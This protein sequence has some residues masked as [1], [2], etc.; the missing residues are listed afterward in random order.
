MLTHLT[1][2]S[3][4]KRLD[5]LLLERGLAPTRK[6]AEGLILAGEVLVDDCPVDKLGALISDTASIRLRQI[7]RKYVG[8]GGEKLEAALDYFSIDV[9]GV[10]ALDVGASTGGFTDCLL[11][12]GAKRVYAVDVGRNQLAYSLRMD[13]RV[14]VMEEIHARDLTPAH[15]SP[16]PN[17]AT[18]DLSFISLRTVLLPATAVLQAGFTALAL[19][20]PQFE[21]SADYVER[22]G[23]VRDTET[24]LL[25]VKLVE[26]HI[27][28]LG[29]RVSGS[30]LSPIRGERKGNQE[31]FIYFSGNRSH[32][33]GQ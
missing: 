22:G 6:A 17:F 13:Q 21:L 7:P 3:Q 28:S 31:Y 12:R 19:V 24:Q 29:Y 5:D 8:R 20:K 26:E 30:Y 27:V 33:E 23:I 2:Q 16:E 14:V 18:L 11:Q 32:G 9:S 15:F 25:A 4:K 1:L 10:V